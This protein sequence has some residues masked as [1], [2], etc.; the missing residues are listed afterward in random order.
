MLPLALALGMTGLGLSRTGS[1][2]SPE[3]E[4]QFRLASRRKL[5]D[6][7]MGNLNTGESFEEFE[8]RAFE[9]PYSTPSATPQQPTSRPLPMPVSPP[10]PQRPGINQPL[11]PGAGYGGLR[12]RPM[13]PQ[14]PR[15][16]F[17]TSPSMSGLGGQLPPQLLMLL[18]SL[19]LRRLL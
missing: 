9:T 5:Y 16:Q 19:I 7:E 18:M 10:Q 6:R 11:G 1:R 12:P 13:P 8:R 17:P 4:I 3:Q 2:A 15:P 14:M